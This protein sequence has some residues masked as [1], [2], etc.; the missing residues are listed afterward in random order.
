MYDTKYQYLTQE[1]AEKTTYKSIKNAYENNEVSIVL[2]DNVWWF[3]GGE[4][5]KRTYDLILK[6]MKRLYPQYKYF[7][8]QNV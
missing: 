6:E 3:E 5:T 1:L 4:T 8:E 2:Y 7:L